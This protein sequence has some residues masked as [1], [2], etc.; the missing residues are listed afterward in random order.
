M[1][2][3]D[4]RTLQLFIATY[5]KSIIVIGG[6]DNYDE[7]AIDD[8]DIVVRINHHYIRQGGPV[9]WLYLAPELKPLKLWPKLVLSYSGIHQGFANAPV[10]IAMPY[11]C[12][13][14]KGPTRFG[15]EHAWTNALCHELKTT[16]LTGIIAIAHI[17]T[18]PI[19][20][21]HITGFN[22]YAD[23]YSIP[24]K[25]DSHELKPQLDWLRHKVTTDRR[26]TIDSELAKLV[27]AETQ[28]EP[29]HHVR[30]ANGAMTVVEVKGVIP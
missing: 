11:Y 1:S 19:S 10:P 7:E 29:V 6:A 18:L 12:L 24:F 2:S 26:I 9:D 25:R 15:A 30:N 16:P 5:G 14:S 13:A 27:E 20:R 28:I 4:I 8:Y 21:L 17:L 23:G 3:I 22:F